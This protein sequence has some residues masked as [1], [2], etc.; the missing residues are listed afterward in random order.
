MP[1][2]T[3]PSDKNKEEAGPSSKSQKEH[4]RAQVRKAQKEHRQRKENYVKHLEQDVIR[5]R[6]MISAVEI[7]STVI[8][9]ENLD[10]KLSLSKANISTSTL[11]D[12]ATFHPSSPD[13]SPSTFQQAG[14]IAPHSN[15]NEFQ[16]PEQNMQWSSS[17]SSGSIVTVNFDDLIDTGYL[18]VSPESDFAPV[19]IIN[20]PDIFNFPT[21]TFAPNHSESAP[22]PSRPHN[23]HTRQRSNASGIVS[24]S[25]SMPNQPDTSSIALNFILALEH[26]CRTH[27][28][29]SSIEFD[30]KGDPSGHELMASTLLYSHAPPPIFNNLDSA[31]WSVPTLELSQLWQMSQSL[32]KGDWEITPVQAWFLLTA[33]YD[34]KRLLGE[35]GKKLNSLKE[36]L[37]R[38]VGCF[39]FGAVMDE[40]K[41]WDAVSGVMG[42]N[43]L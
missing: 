12:P 8:R 43:I 33:S 37:S 41:F 25:T 3:N 39:Q 4:R 30:P 18:Q 32:P 27:F 24:S 2:V 38:L 19:D 36:E 1:N 29:S 9:K 17:V 15:L 42:E 16:S 40:G 10:I 28:H 6:E 5:L 21:N 34:V 11:N 7:E 20:S 14:D 31:S 22:N 35:G 23:Q 26:P 13:R